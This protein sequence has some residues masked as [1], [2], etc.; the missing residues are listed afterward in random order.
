MRAASAA[1]LRDPAQASALWAK[2]DQTIVDQA[3]WVPTVSSHAPELT[4]RRLRNYEY[5]PIWDFVAD[6]AWLR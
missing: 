5:S 2:A 6:Q 1:E 3:Y 4:S